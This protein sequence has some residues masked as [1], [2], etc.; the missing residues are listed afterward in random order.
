MR[1]WTSSVSLVACV[2][3]VSV[4]AGC[5]APPAAEDALSPDV[6]PRDAGPIDLDAPECGSDAECDDGLFCSGVEECTLGR[7]V[8]GPV[9]CDDGIE[10]TIDVC[11]EALRRCANEVPDVDGDGYGDAACL[12]AAGVAL[13]N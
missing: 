1:A 4:I 9:A 3:M 8:S 13:G 10:C 12:D 2:L 7:C 11:D 6:G 5:P